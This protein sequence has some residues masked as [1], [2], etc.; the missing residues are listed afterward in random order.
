[1]PATFG[2]CVMKFFLP[3]VVAKRLIVF[4]E[5]FLCEIERYIY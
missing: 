2:L 5:F 3:Q 4:M 1:L